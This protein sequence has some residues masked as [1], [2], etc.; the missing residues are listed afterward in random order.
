LTDSQ[1]QIRVRLPEDCGGQRLDQALASVF[2]QFSRSQLQALI[3]DGR[4]SVDGG[5][6]RQRDRLRGGEEVVI[7]VPPPRTV[8]WTA[9]ALPLDI[10][11]EDDSIIVLYKPPGLV[12]HPGAG[13]PD[14]TLVNALLHHDPGLAALPRAG[15]VHRLDKDTSGLLVVAR[16]D[17]ARRHLVDQLKRHEVARSYQ[18]VVRGVMVAGGTVEAPVGRHSRDRLRMAVTGRGRAAVT[19]YRV[20]ARYRAH[21][22][23]QL[24]LETGRTHQI[25]VHLAHI[26]Y[27]IVGDP[28]YGGR[29]AVPRGCSAELAEAL[30][31]FRRQALH[32][33]TLALDHPRTGQRLQWTRPPPSDMQELID[34]LARDAAVAQGGS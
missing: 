32:A 29:S 31:G 34:A 25:R 22:L 8:E 6:P 19:H 4:V 11:Y 14:R 26:G 16:T 21:S 13:N 9:Q 17:T 15:V 2:P 7:D 10:E 12:V 27:P 30:R 5:Q 3:R 33:W 28:L 23:L 18:A 20:L 1:Q 24:D